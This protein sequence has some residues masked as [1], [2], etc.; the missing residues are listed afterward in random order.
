MP[1]T[2]RQLLDK[3]TTKKVFPHLQSVTGTPACCA[4]LNG[5]QIAPVNTDT[6]IHFSCRT[7]FK[8]P[9]ALTHQFQGAP[10]TWL[11]PATVFL[12]TCR[13]A[14]E[15]TFAAT[16][17]TAHALA[18]GTIR[19]SRLFRLRMAFSSP[20]IISPCP[21]VSCSFTPQP[22]ITTSAVI[23]SNTIHAERLPAN[24]Q[25]IIATQL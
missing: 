20:L 2:V 11:S 24:H 8:Y 23:R 5:G 18:C 13:V 15:T 3:R 14:T 4:K 1:A 22:D 17:F 9:D 7:G 16:R 19:V 25:R 6:G 10:F 12:A 21:Y